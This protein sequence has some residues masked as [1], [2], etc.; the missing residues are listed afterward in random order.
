MKEEVSA[1]IVFCFPHYYSATGR[2][3]ERRLGVSKADPHPALQ[4][5]VAEKLYLN[6]LGRCRGPVAARN[7]R[8]PGI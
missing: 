5:S 3:A 1:N 6:T 8:R 4:P 7:G 2:V